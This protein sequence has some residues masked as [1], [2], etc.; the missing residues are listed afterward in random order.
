MNAVVGDMEDLTPFRTQLGE[1]EAILLMSSHME[2]N[3]QALKFL[4]SELPKSFVIVRALD[5]VSADSFERAGADR[6]IQPS[7]VIARS[8]LR[9]L[10][11]NEVVRAGSQLTD[12]LKGA[13]S[14]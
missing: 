5:P 13:R 14:V 12:V 6:V 1:A 8:V 9:H 11:E 10:Q 4:K 7:D 2:A 3:L